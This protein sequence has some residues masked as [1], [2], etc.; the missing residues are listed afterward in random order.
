MLR[1]HFRWSR[2]TSSPTEVPTPSFLY[3]DFFFSHVYFSC[4]LC[5][6][7]SLG[8][9]LLLPHLHERVKEDD[10]YCFLGPVLYILFVF[11]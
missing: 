3:H 4:V 2:G 8:G 9:H 6:P 1:G 5:P 7:R 10:S 11:S